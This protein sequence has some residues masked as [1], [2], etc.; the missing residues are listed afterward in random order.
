MRSTRLFMWRTWPRRP[1]IRCLFSLILG[2][3]GSRSSSTFWPL[4]LWLCL[5]RWHSQT[6]LLWLCLGGILLSVGLRFLLYRNT[7]DYARVYYGPD[8]RADALLLGCLLAATVT[9]LT[10][11]RLLGPMAL[12]SAAL[13]A[14]LATL[15]RGIFFFHFGLVL[16][17][18]AS[19][20]IIAYCLNPTGCARWVLTSR[21][22]VYVGSIS[23]GIYL[24]HYVIFRDAR[25]RM[26]GPHLMTFFI[27][28][29][30]SIAVAA[31]SFRYLETPFLNLKKRFRSPRTRTQSPRAAEP[32]ELTTAPTL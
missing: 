28:A 18:L 25:P 6:A 7:S 17:A 24:Y 8:T 31:C 9:W 21:P 30:L 20:M 13:L 15:G 5:V 27:A 14:W 10:K 12:V 4:V 2:H 22:V 29:V 11:K 1:G 23:Y 32:V 3:S 19:A 26:P 16:A